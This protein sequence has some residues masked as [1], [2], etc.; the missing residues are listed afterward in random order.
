MEFYFPTEPG[1]QLA[2]CAACLSALIG[3]VLMFAPR[4]VLR[5]FGLQLPADR[6]DGLSLVRSSLGGLYLGLGVMAVLLAQPMVYLAVGAAFAV[7]AF[8]ALLSILTDGGVTARNSLLL[9][10][11]LLLAALPLGYAL[12]LV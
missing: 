4:L 10:V 9:V 12:G 3:L 6:R 2:F 5:V 8:G 7:S 11:N 1:E